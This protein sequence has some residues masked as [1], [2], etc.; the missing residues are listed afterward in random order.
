M[1]AQVSH[2]ADGL[3][4]APT[5]ARAARGAPPGRDRPGRPA[6][7]SLTRPDQELPEKP[8]AQSAQRP[9]INKRPAADC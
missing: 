6:G 1:A 4:A 3:R 9:A 2:R 7:S 5:F 8:T